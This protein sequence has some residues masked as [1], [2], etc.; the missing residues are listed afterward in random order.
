MAYLPTNSTNKLLLA[1]EEFI[2][3][4]VEIDSI[5][6]SVAC[7]F[8]SNVGGI[9]EFYHSIDGF[10]FAT[11]GDS[12]EFPS[13]SHSRQTSIKGKYFRIRFINGNQNQTSFNLFCKLDK[14]QSEDINVNT[15]YLYDSMTV[16]AGGNDGFNIRHLTTATD[17]VKIDT[18]DKVLF[19]DSGISTLNVT[20][21]SQPPIVI[22]PITISSVS[23]TD[24]NGN[25]ILSNNNGYLQ[26]QIMNN[27]LTVNT[28]SGYALNSTL[29][30]T[31]SKL[32]SLITGIRINA[33]N[34]SAISSDGSNLFVKETNSTSIL[35]GITTIQKDLQNGITVS[36]GITGY[37]TS[38]L[39]TSANTLLTD[40]KNKNLSS[41]SDSVM[42]WAGNDDFKIRALSS[43]IDSVDVGLGIYT[44]SNREPPFPASRDVLS[45]QLC[46]VNNLAGDELINILCDDN[47]HL[48][49]NLSNSITAHID[50]TSLDVNILNSITTHI[51]N[52]VG[53]SGS[54]SVS[55]LPSIAI[56]NTSFEVSNFPTS[57]EVSGGTVDS[58][59][60][61]STG[62]GSVYQT[63]T[64]TS[65]K[66]AAD[67][68]IQNTN[69]IATQDDK[70]NLS[71]NA[72]KQSINSYITNTSLPISFPS[73]ITA[74]GITSVFI[75]NNITSPV[76]SQLIAAHNTTITN[77]HCSSQG[78]LY[79]VPTDENGNHQSLDNH[80]TA[81]AGLYDSAG[82]AIDS[83]NTSGSSYAL[84]THDYHIGLAY[85]ANASLNT[86]IQNTNIAVKVNDGAGNQ[87]G[88]QPYGTG[89]DRA[90]SVNLA[91]QIQNVDVNIKQIQAGITAYI[92][93][94]L[95][96]TGYTF[97]SVNN[98]TQLATNL[99]SLNTA[100]VMYSLGDAPGG[101][102]GIS[103][104]ESTPINMGSGNR[105]NLLTYD[106]T[107]GTL[108]N[109]S[110][111][112]L[113]TINSSI[114]ALHSDNLTINASITALH[115]DLIAINS[116]ITGGNAGITALITAG[117]NTLNNIYAGITTN[118]TILT[119]I[120]GYASSID[121]KTVQL[122]NTTNNSISGYNS[123]NV[124]LSTYVIP[125]KTKTFLFNAYT[126]S[127]GTN[128]FVG[129]NNSNTTFSNANFG[130][131][132]TRQFYIIRSGTS[133]S[134]I[135][136]ALTYID[137]SGNEQ[138][139]VVAAPLPTTLT[140]ISGIS[141]GITIN[142][143]RANQTYTTND[144]ISVCYSNNINTAFCGGGYYHNNSS[145]FT[146]PN[147][148][149]CWVS[150]VSFTASAIDDIRLFRWTAQG[151]R[152]T[153]FCWTGL[154]TFTASASGEYGF[155]GYITAG[156]TLGWGAYSTTTYKIISAT[157][158]V[159]YL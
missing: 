154:S 127:T 107:V 25:D 2:G 58:L 15:N 77:L 34:G 90:L 95:S 50:N 52:I 7:S 137:A 75:N 9:M 130:L 35:N 119:S 96:I 84:S 138:A 27:S 48:Y 149:I 57:F 147:N 124:A 81:Q 33:S 1:N 123:N 143:I 140:A 43:T 64:N 42:V 97:N 5:Y 17:S 109:T 22:P 61:F 6:V 10:S 102:I 44:W 30:D 71:Y 72:G 92:S 100:S 13:G 70:I 37:A 145:L 23:I 158:T 136:L 85:N 108:I 118:S 69:N 49:V 51:D 135:S 4:P 152:E 86:T 142:S 151:I 120:N 53:I 132:N 94:P 114:T 104:L 79:V 144:T 12:Y 3:E 146:C 38:A 105:N 115:N 67:V 32:D 68:Y 73:S 18:L 112:N 28:I 134:S 82:H 110:N 141:S 129:S 122:Y 155:G 83:I 150:S 78:G 54:V 14:I 60:K 125:S 11:Y 126:S 93:N 45:T 148:A 116:S 24:S 153:L 76:Q 133:S 40:I 26:T 63:Y 89:T 128:A 56:T 20:I 8:D 157:I 88:S 121:T 41:N 117:N 99:S 111:T 65:G 103:I 31:N 36:T 106:K 55:S 59:L 46:G 19:N 139:A 156:E 66:Y 16:Y 80:G 159:R 113:T 131:A 39:Q 87:I 98:G 62:L 91:S 101:G 21:H 47:G 74:T 29:S